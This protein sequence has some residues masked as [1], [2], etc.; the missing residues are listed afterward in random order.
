MRLSGRITVFY[1]LFDILLLLLFLFAESYLGIYVI[2]G[3]ALLFFAYSSEI[4]LSRFF[5]YKVEFF[6]GLLFFTSLVVASFFTHAPTLSLNS[7][8]FFG[9]SLTFFF[10]F[11]LLDKKYLQTELIFSNILG[12]VFSLALLSLFFSIF[13]KISESL[14]EMNL[15]HATYGHNHFGT[16]AIMILPVAWYFIFY[17]RWHRKKQ[18][19]YLVLM[20]LLMVNLALSFGRVAM[21]IGFLQFAFFA[22][23]YLFF[24][25]NNGLSSK[26]TIISLSLMA[27]FAFV[28]VNYYSLAKLMGISATCLWPDWENKI[29]KDIQY[30]QRTQY[31]KTA[32]RATKENLLFGYGPGS[33]ALISEKYKNRPD[34]STSFAH[35]FVL[36]VLAESGIVAATIFVLWLSFLF[37]KAA[38]LSFFEQ[39]NEETG[40]NSFLF[41]GII[42]LLGVSLL[43]FDLSYLSLFS[44]M[45]LFFAHIFNSKQVNLK[46]DKTIGWIKLVFNLACAIFI[47]LASLS[48]IIEYFLISGQTNK[49][50]RLFPYFQ[51]H[52]KIFLDDAKSLDQISRQSLATIYG[53]YL[54]TYVHAD[55]VGGFIKNKEKIAEISP[56]TIYS[57]TLLRN[58]AEKDQ[59]MAANE[60]ENLFAKYE[61]LD[62]V[63]YR[64][65]PNVDFEIASFA[66]SLADKYL[67]EGKIERA[68]KFYQIAQGF[69]NWIFV[70]SF[71]R[72][73][74][75][76]ENES[77]KTEFW[78][79]MTSIESKYFAKHAGQIALDHRS[80]LIESLKKNDLV[81]SKKWFLRIMELDSGLVAQME[82]TELPLAQKMADFYVKQNDWSK[83]EEAVKLVYEIGSRE[84]RL[85]LGNFYL[86]RG[87]LESA[88]MSYQAC[89]DGW[90]DEVHPE[91]SQ[92]LNSDLQQTAEFYWSA[93]QKIK[94]KN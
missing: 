82:Y 66:L 91:C 30:D 59:E 40:I 36:Q 88:K 55:E 21:A 71:P 49:A 7:L 65:S 77:Q 80:L 92:M 37:L 22:G 26:V 48:L 34:L 29:C 12:V 87:Q 61:K 5:R 53:N 70:E 4:D 83:A 45:L 57:P 47:I 94:A 56:W 41:L 46:S 27:V 54:Y 76:F 52:M 74:Y 23:K 75:Q 78:S 89:L 13:P 31:F 81:N 58:L 51:S 25:K 72:F 90:R 39:K 73:L 68:S 17:Y 43:D 2:G 1:Y 19:P 50:A 8:I 62:E 86:M 42:S 3:M 44:L 15:I 63:G 20:V 69:Y 18:L 85:Q 93:G 28:L 33:Y 9:F 24:K 10:F 16:V 67:S 35:N 11:L 79:K 6:W 64:S 14:P 84:G 32:I 38:K 60:L